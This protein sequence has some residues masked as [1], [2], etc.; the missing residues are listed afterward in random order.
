MIILLKDCFCNINVVLNL[1]V[2]FVNDFNVKCYE[3]YCFINLYFIVFYFDCMNK[4]G[5]V[6]I[7]FLKI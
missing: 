1:R 6:Y 4:C 3:N 2:Y 5:M 7:F